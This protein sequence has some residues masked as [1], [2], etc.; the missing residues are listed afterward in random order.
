M[1]GHVELE[2]INTSTGPGPGTSTGPGIILL[3]ICRCTTSLVVV[4]MILFF[5]SI[6]RPCVIQVIFTT[7]V[8][9][10]AVVITVGITIVLRVVDCLG[11]GK[12]PLTTCGGQDYSCEFHV[13][14][15]IFG[16][17]VFVV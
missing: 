1:F 15:P 10:V 5:G 7:I 6:S 12:E 8:I 16:F 17:L 14:H 2:F 4:V 11:E 9:A 3:T 13:S